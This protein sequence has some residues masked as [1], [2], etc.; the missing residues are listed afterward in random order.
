MVMSSFRSVV[1]RVPQVVEPA[2]GAAQRVDGGIDVEPVAGADH[3]EG[4][5]APVT[6]VA[7]R[8]GHGGDV[9]VVLDDRR[10]DCVVLA[11]DDG[12][13]SSPR[14]PDPSRLPVSDDLGLGE[15]REDT[16]G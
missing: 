10:G 16:A 2:Y 3:A 13:L 14:D 4:R 6:V 5:D 8:D 11:A 12:E 7:Q 9:V 15:G 1:Q